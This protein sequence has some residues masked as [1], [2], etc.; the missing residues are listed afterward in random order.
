VFIWLPK[1][2]W[3]IEYVSKNIH[4]LMGY[5][6]AMFYSE[7]FKFEQLIHPDDLSR[8]KQ[9]VE[10]F[11]NLDVSSYE[12]SYRLMHSNGTYQWYYDFTVPE[13]D[14]KGVVTRLRGYIF[15]Q[16]RL[17]QIEM[18]LEKERLR[19]QNIL[20]GTQVG[21]W[22]WEIQTGKLMINERWAELIGY[23]LEELEPISIQT[24]E[25]FAH[26]EDL[27]KSYALIAQHTKGEIDH[28]EIECRMRHKSGEW[29]WIID[30]G[31]I[32][33]WDE[34][35]NPMLMCGFHVD[36]TK[37]KLSEEVLRQTEKLSAF[38]QLAGGV[39]HD[40]NN[41]LMIISSY[42]DLLSALDLSDL[43]LNYIDKIAT[44]SLR[45]SHLVKQLLAF[46]KKG[47]YDEKLTDMALL[48]Q[49]TMN[50]L[51]HTLDKNI[52]ISTTIL[53]KN[54]KC[55]VDASLIENA[56][57]NI[58]INSRDAMP[59]GGQLDVLLER[60]HISR[61][62][63]TAISDLIP[64]TY[65][66]LQIS[67]TGCGIDEATIPHIFEP[68]YTTKDAGTGMGLS[69]VFGTIRRH[70]GGVNVMSVV[71]LGTTFEIY[72]PVSELEAEIPSEVKNISE[73]TKEKYQ[74]MVVDDE[75]L[76]C[77]VLH[78]FL[79]GLGYQV[80]AFSDTREA[81]SYYKEHQQRVDLVILDVVM[82]HMNGYELLECMLQENPNL[83]AIYLSG[84]S[85]D[86]KRSQKLAQNVCAFIEKPVKLRDLENVLKEF[87]FS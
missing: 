27:E 16:T 71:E 35:K 44:V 30:R 54:I 2:G 82:P 62:Q 83:Q 8:V 15:N 46:S 23:T 36:I 20:D 84:Y 5:P 74:L 69:A 47:K 68:F 81:L 56:L 61:P 41:Q 66:R 80:A 10:R 13:K 37:K 77:D 85:E 25:R 9:E 32:V 63:K 19:L 40:F 24:W 87:F 75:S 4:E 48:I 73:G 45:S 60:V 55:M 49:N 51:R 39:A 70:K 22:E 79:S 38:G 6:S 1:E 58:C 50:I 14:D 59:R 42:I 3:P 34:N 31:K 43:A 53:N 76:I 28:Y 64:G 78:T 65:M 11:R 21:T 12:Q 26:P 72:L 52:N 33:Q 18:D 86:Y 67:D 7:K 17:K 57:I 29:I